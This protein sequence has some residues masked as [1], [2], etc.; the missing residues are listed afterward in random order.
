M[1]RLPCD[2]IFYQNACQLG[3]CPGGS[4]SLTSTCSDD[5]VSMLKDLTLEICV[6][7]LRWIAAHRMHKKMPIYRRESVGI[8]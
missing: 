3:I 5:Q 8:E 6:P 2:F 7:S 1:R 4:Q